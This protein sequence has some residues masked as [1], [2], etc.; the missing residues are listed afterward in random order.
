M[1][2]RRDRILPYGCSLDVS[3]G[4]THQQEHGQDQQEIHD[5]L[6]TLISTLFHQ[7]LIHVAPSPPFPWFNRAD[8]RMAAHITLSLFVENS[9]QFVGR[10]CRHHL[11]LHVIP[12]EHRS[13][14][15]DPSV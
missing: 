13:G 14:S 4:Q 7:Q 9:V 3:G 12:T 1:G 6:S 15:P 2:A 10:W 8:D 5:R 11:S